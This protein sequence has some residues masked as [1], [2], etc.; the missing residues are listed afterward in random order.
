MTI[1]LL[2]GTMLCAECL[3]FSLNM[4]PYDINF[5]WECL[6]QHNMHHNISKIIMMGIQILVL[7]L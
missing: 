6:R 2:L 7:V 4:G 3:I 1:T 5:A